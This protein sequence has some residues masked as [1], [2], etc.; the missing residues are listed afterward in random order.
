MKNIELI[1]Q[2]SNIIDVILS[3]GIVSPNE[4]SVLQDWLEDNSVEFIGDDYNSLIIPLQ[5]FIEDGQLTNMEID[6]I[7]TILTKIKDSK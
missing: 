1:E 4:I 3:D 6:N 5:K 2:I 7:K